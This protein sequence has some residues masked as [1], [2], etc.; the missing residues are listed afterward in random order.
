MS[1]TLEEVHPGEALDAGAAGVVDK[2]AAPEE[3]AAQI[4]AVRAA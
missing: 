2:V 4:R 1:T 3:I